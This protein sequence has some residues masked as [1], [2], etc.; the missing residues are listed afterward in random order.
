MIRFT[1]N[2]RGSTR[3]EETS[4][5]RDALRQQRQFRLEQ[6]SELS[7]APVRTALST[8]ATAEQVEAQAQVAR[9][10]RAAA[11]S[12]LADVDAALLRI[13]QGVFGRCMEC[14]GD[15]QL[16]RLEILPMAALCM[17]CQRRQ[18]I[19]PSNWATTKTTP[20]ETTR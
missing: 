6:L 16:A 18:E 1:P 4:T 8:G 17:P 10:L 2:A 19:A 12:A 7:A 5:F 13:E 14:S 9:L 3:I 20:H 15:I 11:L